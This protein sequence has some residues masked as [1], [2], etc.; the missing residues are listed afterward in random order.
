MAPSFTRRIELPENVINQPAEEST[1]H[2]P[3]TMIPH[4]SS[5]RK[6]LRKWLLVT[7]IVLTSLLLILLT[8]GWLMEGRLEKILQQEINKQLITRVEVKDISL[9]FLRSFPQV[10]LKFTDVII[11]SIKGDTAALL[12]TEKLFLQFSLWDI[13]RKNYTIQYIGIDNGKLS[14]LI[15]SDGKPNYLILKEQKEEGDAFS[16]DLRKVLIKNV[17]ITYRDQKSKII[18]RFSGKRNTFKGN[19]SSNEYKLKA[20]GEIRINML[21]VGT[22]RFFSGQD[23]WLDLVMDIDNH[24]DLYVIRRGKL[25]VEGLPFLVNGEIHNASGKETLTLFIEGNRMKTAHLL[26]LLP[27][28]YA[29][30]SEEYSPAG[31]ITFS[32]SITGSYAGSKI[33]EARFSIG[34][35]DASLT[36]KGTGLVLKNIGCHA[37]YLYNQTENRLKISDLVS[38]LGEGYLKGSAELENL[39]NPVIRV[40]MQSELSINDLIRF[41]QVDEL[42]DGKGRIRLML[43]GETAVAVSKDFNI[44]HLLNSRT[45]GVIELSGAAFT[46]QGDSRT[47]Q[48]MSGKFLFDNNDVKIQDFKGSVNHSTYHVAGYLRNLLPYLFFDNQDLEIKGTL[49]SADVDLKDILLPGT[50]TNT[51]EGSIFRL[52]AR[53]SGNL[54]VRFERLQ[55]DDFRSSDIRGRVR[56]EKSRIYAEEVRMNAFDGELAGA[57]MISEAEGEGYTFNCEMNTSRADIRQLFGQ[58]RNFGQEDI[59]ERNLRGKLTSR[60]RIFSR[61]TPGLDFMLPSLEAVGELVLEEGALIDYEPVK[62]LARYTRLDDLSDIRFH[63]LRNEI[64]INNQR[65]IIPEMMI[66]SDAVD[67]AVS[68]THTFDGIISYH[69]KMLLSELLS[70][71]AGKQRYADPSADLTEQDSRGRFILYLA[72]EGTVDHPTVKYDHRGRREQYRKE[73][74]TE[75]E[76][77][78]ELLKKEFGTFIQPDEKLQKT[79]KTEKQEGVILIEW[80]DD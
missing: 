62:A 45:N 11:P 29:Y 55:F 50:G 59:T 54:D 36:H 67:L 10:S 78:R 57:V 80:D 76:G 24:A 77:V 49:T 44:T 63:T 43:K 46:I 58:F 37:E 16:I 17:D 3:V 33:P 53:I 14:I 8:A 65:V 74:I 22:D 15:P 48:G 68:G 2:E 66:R 70:K 30:L 35:E 51:G 79:A 73:L 75:K 19:F 12:E 42:K 52:P 60:I 18:L 1:R 39:N 38:V 41:I 32:G 27:R 34:I 64:R 9:S 21:Q 26:D 6:K 23:A 40:D 20:Y 56:V 5:G 71:K 28:S 61:L 4:I 72:L 25:E 13:L 7:T 47:Y 31:N 69:I